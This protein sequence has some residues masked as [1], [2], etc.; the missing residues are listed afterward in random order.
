ML[1]AYWVA[2]GIVSV[3]VGA[4]TNNVRTRRCRRHHLAGRRDRRGSVAAGG[5]RRMTRLLRT[6]VN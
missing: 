6:V 2:V 1:R 4:A 3:A 5:I